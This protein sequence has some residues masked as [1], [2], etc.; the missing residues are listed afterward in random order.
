MRKWIYRCADN[1]RRLWKTTEYCR[2]TRKYRK[3]KLIIYSDSW[4][5]LLGID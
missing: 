5:Y 3:V 4:E 1:T 2:R